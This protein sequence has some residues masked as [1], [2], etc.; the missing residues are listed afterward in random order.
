M[1]CAPD[2]TTRDFT[3]SLNPARVNRLIRAPALSQGSGKARTAAR[4]RQVQVWHQ[5]LQLCIS[6]SSSDHV[7]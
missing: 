1:L 3:G 2:R 7:L 4:E 5:S 6:A